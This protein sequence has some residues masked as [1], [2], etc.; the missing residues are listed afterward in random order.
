MFGILNLLKV[1]LSLA[2]IASVISFTVIDKSAPVNNSI[3]VTNTNLTPVAAGQNSGMLLT[4]KS[5]IVTGVAKSFIPENLYILADT[6]TI[7]ANPGPANNG[8]S[9]GWAMFFD[10]I[11]STRNIDVT[12]M[13]T[14]STAA[15]SSSYSVEVFTRSGTALGG[16]VGSGPGSSSN[17]WTSIGIVPVVQGLTSSGI[18][19]IF[20]L[21]TISVPAGDTVG[22]AVRFNSVGPRYYGTGSPPY[23]YYS[24]TNLTLVTGDGRSAPFTPTGNWFAS[25]ALTGV[26]RYVIGSTVGISNS[27]TGIPE[28]FILAQN[29]PNPFNPSTT[30]EFAL[31]E[32]SNVTLKVYNA[33]GQEVATLVNGEYSAGTY[34]VHWNAGDLASGVYFY[35]LK[36]GKFTE[37]K[38]LV[39]VK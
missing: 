13:S 39:L 26:I 36:A 15:A 30:I 23:S 9:A 18:S 37:T 17:G 16:P 12:Q 21:P 14:A 31:P 4:Y 10:L 11:A 28:G 19:L 7:P 38:R 25:R 24:D 32:R 34:N 22:V 27:G 6:F 3:S 2:F 33:H 35:S 8:G 29:Y 5:G 1:S 20:N